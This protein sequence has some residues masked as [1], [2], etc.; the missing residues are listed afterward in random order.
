VDWS[1]VGD[2]G[3]KGVIQTLFSRCDGL[4]GCWVMNKKG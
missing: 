1:H 4:T 3:V 2:D